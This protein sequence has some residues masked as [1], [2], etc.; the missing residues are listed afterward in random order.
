MGRSAP[1]RQVTP[2]CC[3]P[4]GASDPAWNL[5]GPVWAGHRVHLSPVLIP[6]HLQF[7]AL[8]VGPQKLGFTPC[9][10]LP[11][12]GSIPKSSGRD[13]DWWALAL[14]H[15]E[16]GVQQGP[17]CCSLALLPSEHPTELQALRGVHWPLGGHWWHPHLAGQRP[18]LLSV[19]GTFCTPTP[20]WRPAARHGS[21]DLG[22]AAPAAAATWPSPGSLSPA[23]SG[24][25]GRLGRLGQGEYPWGEPSSRVPLSSTGV[26]G[27]CSAH[28]RVSSPHPGT[29][30]VSSPP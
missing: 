1:Q 6:W 14:Q 10:G 13:S 22:Q 11:A 20:G 27:P 18:Q 26:A 16:Q 19:S 23:L 9:P 8:E 3:K 30:R 12:A 21:V 24:P 17:L 15:L 28:Q 4:W 2:P 29:V 5:G 7:L 25:T